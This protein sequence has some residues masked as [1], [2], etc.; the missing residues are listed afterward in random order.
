MRIFGLKTFFVLLLELLHGGA[1]SQS[2][3]LD[4]LHKTLTLASDSQ[5][6]VMLLNQIAD[7]Y[8]NIQD[9]NQS[10]R[11]AERA[12]HLADKLGYVPGKADALLIISH[13]LF[14]GDSMDAALE[15]VCLAK[16]LSEAENY[17]FGITK[18]YMEQGNLLLRK[19]DSPGSRESFRNAYRLLE[20]DSDKSLMIPALG[21]ISDTYMK[22]G[23]VEEALDTLLLAY[24]IAENITDTFLLARLAYSITGIYLNMPENPGK[25]I[26]LGRKGVEFSGQSRNVILQCLSASNLGKMYV[27]INNPDSALFY[28]KMALDLEEK[29]PDPSWLVTAWEAMADLEI[30]KGNYPAATDW[31]LKALENEG[32]DE[33]GKYSDKGIYLL[34]NLGNLYLKMG[35]VNSAAKYLE[36]A[37]YNYEMENPRLAMDIYEGLS[38]LAQQQGNSE[39]AFLYYK[40]YISARDS[41][42]NEENA[43][44]M[45]R[46]EL[47][48]EFEV[49]RAEELARQ[50]QELAV[51]DAK[52][53]QQWIIFGFVISGIIGIGGLGFYSYRQRQ[54]RYRTELELASLRAQMNPHFIFNC[55]NSIYRYTRE[56][57]IETAGKYLQKFSRL[58][59]LVLENSR[60]EKITLARDLEAL[61]LYVDIEALRFKEKLKVTFS[62]SPE[63]DQGF[64]KIPGMLI[65]PYV[66]NAIWHG[67]MHRDTGGEITITIRQ[68]AEDRL[69]IEIVDNG[70][71]RAAAAEIEDKSTRNYTSLGSQITEER[72]KKARHS[73]HNMK[74]ETTD[75]LDNRGNAAG[76]KVVIEIPV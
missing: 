54:G 6:K 27:R 46:I 14:F 76:T 37:R 57:D 38:N 36:I 45:T 32:P 61:R 60:M 3:L 9:M 52:T 18:A 68:P 73:K 43:R 72:L 13:Q 53:R 4:S 59:R 5:Q 56:G 25:G 22:E 35:D 69:L 74:L 10:R 15:K 29:L 16:E 66:E 7:S 39:E 24:R 55:L 31:L 2:Y 67:L 17:I 70:V 26:G 12:Y 33:A 21:G 44:R 34:S 65:Q 41:V 30:S 20:L 62:I 48:H 63:I 51:R 75:L 8:L 42:Y 1:Y 58:L 19:N 11:Y 64:L 23:R 71:G 47:T 40:R 28:L 50:Q 49:R